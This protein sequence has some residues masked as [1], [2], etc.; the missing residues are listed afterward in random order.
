M[1][2]KNVKFIGRYKTCAN[3]GG[4]LSPFFNATKQ[5]LNRIS[6]KIVLI[7]LRVVE[8]P[9]CLEEL[10]LRIYFVFGSCFRMLAVIFVSLFSPLVP[11]LFDTHLA[12]NY[13]VCR[14]MQATR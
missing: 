7:R 1:V 3:F 14:I 11:H 13:F 9:E 4:S 10:K 5:R 2:K 12:R 6:K 8:S